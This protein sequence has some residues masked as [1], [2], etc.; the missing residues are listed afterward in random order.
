MPDTR[1]FLKK[2]CGFWGRVIISN[3]IISL[4]LDTYVCTYIYMFSI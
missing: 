4:K 2:V 1:I 3:G